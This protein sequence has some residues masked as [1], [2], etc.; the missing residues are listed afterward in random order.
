[1][2]KVARA[3]RP[4]LPPHARGCTLDRKSHL[5]TVQASPAR[6]GMYLL[7]RSPAPRVRR[8][9]RT[10]GDV[11]SPTRPP[12]SSAWLPPHARGCTLACASATHAGRASPARAGMYLTPRCGAHGRGGFPRTRGDVPIT[13]RLVAANPWLPPHARGCTR[14]SAPRPRGR[15]AS[16]ARA[17]MYPRPCTRGIRRRGFPRTRGDV[18]I[19]ANAANTATALPPH[20]RGCTEWSRVTGITQK[21]SPARA[22][23][24]RRWR[25]GRGGRGRFPRTR[26]DVPMFDFAAGDGGE[27]PPHARGCTQSSGSRGRRS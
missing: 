20:A 11:P 8:F 26:G 22:G 6:A 13:G 1:M 3:D 7:P 25:S 21:A 10:R 4:L 2:K 15:G 5:A 12:A 16:P 24:Y 14:L 23:M 9:P 27:L 18:P 17:G 19:A